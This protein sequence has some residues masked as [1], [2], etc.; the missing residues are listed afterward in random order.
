MAGSLAVHGSAPETDGVYVNCEEALG[1]CLQLLADRSSNKGFFIRC[2]EY[3]L[4]ARFVLHLTRLAVHCS[5]EDCGL[6]WH[7]GYDCDDHIALGNELRRFLADRWLRLSESVDPSTTEL[8]YFD[9]EG[10]PDVD[11]YVDMNLLPLLLRVPRSRLFVVIEIRTHF[12][13]TH[14]I[15]RM[16]ERLLDRVM[17]GSLNIFFL[18]DGNTDHRGR[19]EK[20]DIDPALASRLPKLSDRP[21]IAPRRLPRAL[22]ARDGI[23]RLLHPLIMLNQAAQNEALSYL[24][25]RQGEDGDLDALITNDVLQR[26]IDGSVG[27]TRRGLDLSKELGNLTGVFRDVVP[28]GAK[29][30]SF[31]PPCALFRQET[32]LSEVEK[33]LTAS[34]Q[35]IDLFAQFLGTGGNPS[36]LAELERLAMDWGNAFNRR[37]AH[38][39]RILLAY[40]SQMLLTP[41]YGMNAR[42]FATMEQLT[43]GYCQFAVTLHTDDEDKIRSSYEAARWLK[44]L[45]DLYEIA[46]FKKFHRVDS[47]K[48]N[49]IYN[50]GVSY[51]VGLETSELELAGSVLYTRA[52][53]LVGASRRSDARKSFLDGAVRHRNMARQ[54]GR[55]DLAYQWF[56]LLLL[57]I[58][59]EEGAPLHGEHRGMLEQFVGAHGTLFT[60]DEIRDVIHRQPGGHIPLFPATTAEGTANIYFCNWDTY[61]AVM[62]AGMVATHLHL[63]PR[64]ILVRT[65]R[66]FSA[67]LKFD[68]AAHIVLAAPDT[69]DL[70]PIVGAALPELERLY[71]LNLTRK[72]HCHTETEF[73]GR[74]LIILAGCGLGSIIDA[75]S[76]V[77][78][79]GLIAKGNV[80]MLDALLANPLFSSLLEGCSGGVAG[81]LVEGIANRLWPSRDGEAINEKLEKVVALLTEVAE[82]A[83]RRDGDRLK[84]GIAAQGASIIDSRLQGQS[85]AAALMTLLLRIFADA[86][87]PAALAALEDY[88]ANNRIALEEQADICRVMAR[89]CRNRKFAGNARLIRVFDDYSGFFSGHLEEVSRQQE[90]AR[91]L[92]DYP[93]R[94]IGFLREKLYTR[95]RVM[96]EELA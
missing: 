75:W 64:L 59:C 35:L 42:H 11:S 50:D 56:E 45:A 9:V 18:C 85:D 79:A 30:L 81:A 43:Y 52:W 10:M 15:V 88:A 60:F 2:N 24:S 54:A 80:S 14:N 8:I 90:I 51:I 49:E 33:S 39:S 25:G 74:R 17:P 72:F 19:F 38:A 89:L 58:S 69:P 84:D 22:P 78:M 53:H 63:M 44:N 83:N 36:A 87:L 91:R 23:V 66:D 92:G 55:L 95:L 57:G 62:I 29:I 93:A 1:R 32:P 21:D 86:N 28:N 12:R 4:S 37:N 7:T 40:F 76:K 3:D 82:G 5:G 27:V 77:V 41:R 34:M 20:I 16:A 13:S 65:Q 73:E 26:Y 47:R 70:G 71:Q 48:I 94:E 31:Q 46:S 96:R 6:H 68:A 61:A 67:G